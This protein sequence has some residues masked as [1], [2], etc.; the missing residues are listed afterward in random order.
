[1][2]KIIK[3]TFYSNFLQIYVMFVSIQI[4]YMNILNNIIYYLIWNILMFSYA[5]SFPSNFFYSF[6]YYYIVCIYCRLR[7]D[8]LNNSLSIQNRFLVYKNINIFLSEY[9]YLLS[10]IK[11]YNNFWSKYLF[12]FYYLLTPFQSDWSSF[13]IL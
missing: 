13:N 8:S 9:N 2:G 5:Y 6:Y 4:K 11:Q 7:L 10:I 12:V 3:I 1:M